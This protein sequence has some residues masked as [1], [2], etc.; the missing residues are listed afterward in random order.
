MTC[1]VLHCRPTHNEYKYLIHIP[2]FQRYSDLIAFDDNVISLRV[3]WSKRKWFFWTATASRIDRL[4]E[5]SKVGT[6]ILGSLLMKGSRSTTFVWGDRTWEGECIMLKSGVLLMGDM[7]S[8][9]VEG[10]GGCHCNY[11]WEYL[12]C[13]TSGHVWEIGECMVRGALG[14]VQELGDCRTILCDGMF[15]KI[16]RFWTSKVCPGTWVAWGENSMHA[17]TQLQDVTCAGK[18]RV[19]DTS[20]VSLTWTC[21][22][23]ELGGFST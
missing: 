9:W 4:W 7:Y 13:G 22:W 12:I 11:A 3:W 10:K 19:N 15:G 14:W 18:M 5:I 23:G 8:N 20:P 16:G 6:T 2:F 21:P 17:G 1:P